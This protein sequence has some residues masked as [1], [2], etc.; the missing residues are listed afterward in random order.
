MNNYFYINGIC[1][2]IYFTVCLLCGLQLSFGAFTQGHTRNPLLSRLVGSIFLVMSC[3]AVCYMLSALLDSELLMQT[4]VS[5]DIFMF[6]GIACV[7]YVL[8]S[9]NEPSKGRLAALAWPFV[10]IGVL[11]ICFP[12]WLIFLFN[13]A[14]LILL[15]QMIYFGIVFIRRERNLDDLYADPERHSLKWMLVFI[16][17]FI[18]WWVV[19]IVFNY[20]ALSRWYD[21]AVYLYMT[22]TILFAFTKVSNYATPVILATQQEIENANANVNVNDLQPATCNLQPATGDHNVVCLKQLMEQEHLYLNPDL[23]V[24]D[25]VK[26]LGTNTKY[27][28]A[29]MRNEMHTTFSQLVNEYRIEHAKQLLQ[30]KDE[31]VVNLAEQCGFNSNQSFYRTFS[32]FTGTTPTEWRSK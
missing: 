9:N 17:L 7:S 14:A 13:L 23:T 28:S 2:A 20:T 31:K 18:G 19:C 27:F 16:G 29:L 24:E 6:T 30:N 26:R 21:Q 10:V 32:K 11:N 8:Y 4:G 3:S 25:V 5:I 22:G 12:E 15:A 1:I